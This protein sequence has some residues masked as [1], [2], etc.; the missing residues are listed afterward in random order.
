MVYRQLKARQEINQEVQ[1][2][3]SDRPVAIIARQSTTRQT[4]ENVES[5]RLQVE[6]AVERYIQQ[7]WSQDIITVR[8]AGSGNRGVSASKL[9]IDQR[10]ELQDTIADI[11]AGS[12]K[13]VGAYSVSRLFRDKWGVQVGTLTH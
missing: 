8:V 12:I 10:S 2:Q 13:L 3:L 1:T 6:D 7:G 9:R 11:K 4:K 5:L